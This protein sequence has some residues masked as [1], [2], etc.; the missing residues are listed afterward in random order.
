MRHAC[1]ATIHAVEQHG[2][3]NG[4]GRILVIA[5]HRLN[6]G[7][8]AGKQIGRSEQIGQDVDAATAALRCQQWLTLS[9][10]RIRHGLGL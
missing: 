2:N 8:K 7:V 4:N 9:V 1:H 3:E 10:V 5:I 6:N